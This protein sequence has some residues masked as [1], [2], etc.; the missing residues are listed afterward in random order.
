M[1]ATLLAVGL[2][3]CAP[4]GAPPIAPVE[5]TVA[6]ADAGSIVS[7]P[8]AAPPPR[9]SDR[10]CSARVR[11]STIKTPSNCQ[12][13]ERLSRGPGTLT[14]PC[15]GDGEAEI[16]FGEHRFEGTIASGLLELALTTELDWDDGCHWE[17]RQG[18][19]GALRDGRR[20]KLTWSYAEQPVSGTR[21]AGACKAQADIDVELED[22]EVP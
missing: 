5:V 22:T 12:L 4:Q 2:A 17:T 13:D 9:E 16:V 6:A 20:V 10:R 15:A 11:A 3:A 19:R 8:L 14:F 18:I 21:C 1:R 7:S